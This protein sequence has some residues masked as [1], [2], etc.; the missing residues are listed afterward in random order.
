MVTL[1]E[2]LTGV[3]EITRLR[4]KY[5]SPFTQA[6]IGTPHCQEFVDAPHDHVVLRLKLPIGT[7][8]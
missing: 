3:Y 2:T 4:P 6:E 5:P 8:A 7:V 1:V